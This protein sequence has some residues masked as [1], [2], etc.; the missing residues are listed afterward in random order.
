MPLR[1]VEDSHYEPGIAV[2]LETVRSFTGPEG[3]LERRGPAEEISRAV[4]AWVESKRQNAQVWRRTGYSA[5]ATMEPRYIRSCLT[6]QPH[7]FLK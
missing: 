2:T 3:V 1:N 4:R 6:P 7:I 5:G